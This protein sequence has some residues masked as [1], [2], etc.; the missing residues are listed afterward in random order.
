MAWPTNADIATRLARTLSTTEED[1]ADLLIEQ[2]VAAIE[3]IV[4]CTSDQGVIT[5]SAVEHVIS[6]ITPKYIA[7]GVT[8]DDVV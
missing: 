8:G 2:A 7:C 3:L 6:S 1:Q 5:F 4:A